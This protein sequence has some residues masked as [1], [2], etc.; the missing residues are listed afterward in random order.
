[1]SAA[2]AAEARTAADTQIVEA[3]EL[4]RLLSNPSR[5]AILRRL[6]GGEATV[7]EME[8]TLQIRQPSLSQQLGELRK[9]GVVTDRR[10]GKAMVYRLTDPKVRA[11]IAHEFGEVDPPPPRVPASASHAAVFGRVLDAADPVDAAG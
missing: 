6:M 3:A 10:D 5:L 8:R 2:A 11:T 4:F 9:A 1:M 7:G